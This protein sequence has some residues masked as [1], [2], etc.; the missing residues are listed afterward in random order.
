MGELTTPS[1]QGSE[2]PGLLGLQSLE[3]NK[4]VWDFQQHKLYFLGPGDYDLRRALPPGTDVF[5][6]EKAPS[7]HAVLPC[8]EFGGSSSSGSHDQ[9]TLTLHSRQDPVGQMSGIP[10]PP[11]EPPVLTGV[12]A[13]VSVPAPPLA[14]AS[15][16]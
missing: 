7:G 12:E 8:C 10:P 11:A 4:A 14:A 2:L 5:Q 15:R 13:P 3:N 9:H 1:V 6:L 16:L